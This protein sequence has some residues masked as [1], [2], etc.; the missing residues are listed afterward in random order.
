MYG[1]TCK[2]PGCQRDAVL[3]DRM[4]PTA[5]DRCAQPAVGPSCHC[6]SHLHG[7]WQPASRPEPREAFGSGSAHC[8]LDSARQTNEFPTWYWSQTILQ[9]VKEFNCMVPL[10]C[11]HHSRLQ[12]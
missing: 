2:Q 11:Y 4:D 12:G 6:T 3:G 5:W 10:E 8:G 9:F 1:A 7:A